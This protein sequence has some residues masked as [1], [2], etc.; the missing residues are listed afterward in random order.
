M[1]IADEM[2]AEDSMAQLFWRNGK[3]KRSQITKVKLCTTEKLDSIVNFRKQVV[4]VVVESLGQSI[5][6]DSR[7][8]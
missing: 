8:G 6:I 5:S 3:I 1:D 2:T 7:G 4:V